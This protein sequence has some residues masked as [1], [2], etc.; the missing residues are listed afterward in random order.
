MSKL[1]DAN[2]VIDRAPRLAR[3][4]RAAMGVAIGTTATG[5]DR[6]AEAQTAPDTQLAPVTAVGAVAHPTGGYQ[7]TMPT[8]DKLTQPLLDTP[9]SIS[10]QPRAL[11]DDKGVTTLRDALRDVPGV[12]LQAGEGGQQG[13]NLSIRGFN[14][15]ND[16]YLDGMHDFGSYYRDPFNLES[17]EVLKGPS[18]I[19]FG[20]G[21]TGG[22]INQVSKQAQL[23]PVTTAS[24][25]FGTDGT[26]RTT[27]DMDRAIPGVTGA[28]IH[29]NGM[30]DD[31]GVAGQD[32]T[33]NRRFGLAP[34]LAFGL[35]TDTRVKLS[36]FHQQSY[37]TPSYGLPWIN[38]KPA[39][40]NTSNFYGY[41][42]SD[43]FRSNVDV[44]TIRVEH[45][46][47]DNVTV[48]NQLRYGSYQR[49][50]AVTEPLITG[51]TASQD[52]VPATLPLSS[53]LV[54]QH[55]IALSS[56]ETTLDNDTDV[57]LHFKTGPVSH[58]LVTGIE[59]SRQTSDPTRYVGTQATV[60]LLTPT[61]LSSSVYPL[62]VSSIA[63][64]TANAYAVY[65]TDTIKI[66][67]KLQVI[68]GW[69]FDRY[70]STYHQIVAP[71]AHVTR[72][73][74]MPSWRAAIVYK[75][76]PNA[77]VYASYG[78]SFDPSAEALSLTASTAAV[79]PEKSTNYEIGGKWDTLDSKLSLTTALYRLAMT[80]VRETSL[81]D[82][83]TSILAGDYR[84]YGFEVGVTGHITPRLQIFAG[85]SYNDAEVVASPNI[86]ELGHQP[87]NAPKHTFSTFIEYKTPWYGIEVGGGVNLV[88]SR[89]ASS[90]PV[91]GT[92]IIERA[93]GYTIGQLFAK[94]PINDHITA[95]VNITNISDETYYD[96]LHPGHIITGAARAA[97][98]TLNFKL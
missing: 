38:G 65:A 36:Y 53:T 92:T 20:R 56:R 44:G 61:T 70:D 80:N 35:G 12:S 93:P 76:V 17:V 18:S 48:T 3:V 41:S 32:Y 24:V 43:Y 6:H 37:D 69:R 26:K 14:A 31:G 57:N 60:S 30:I 19:L 4:T 22:I 72:D 68:G 34:E 81:V 85:Y 66:G 96:G 82:P 8:I 67:D 77:S 86:N 54:H 39:P 90:L 16:F 7:V 78:T 40:V 50:I 59:V 95:Q 88:S 98:F 28:A 74:D 64:N 51:Y 11:L 75:P 63:G 84:V 45:D 21:S 47:N 23:D 1:A 15:Q 27:F 42:Q 2:P 97:L 83:T 89:T 10:V 58:D 33:K 29:L 79:A 91:T 49:S 87:P 25:A 55:V 62:T 94:A 52:I 5:F 71:V 73:D 9:Q 46:F 13:D